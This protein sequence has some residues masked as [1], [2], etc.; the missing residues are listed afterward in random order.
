[1]C[2]GPST[3]GAG[4]K[5]RLH[6]PKA[7]TYHESRIKKFTPHCI[8]RLVMTAFFSTTYTPKTVSPRP[9]TDMMQAVES[10]VVAAQAEEGEAPA[11]ILISIEGNIG[12]GKSTVLNVLKQKHPDWVFIDEPV[13]TW[14]A[15]KNADGTNLL[16]HF[17]QDQ[18]R[19]AY[20]FQNCA[21]LSRFT[22]IENTILKTAHDDKDKAYVNYMKL[23]TIYVLHVFY[24]LILS[25]VC[26]P[27]LH[28]SPQHAPCM[29]S[30]QLDLIYSVC[31]C[32]CRYSSK[33]RIY[34][35]ERCLDTDKRVFAQMMYEDKKMNKIEMDLYCKWYHMLHQAHSG[36]A[37]ALSAIVYINTAPDVCAERIVK[38]S[39]GGEEGI[40]LEYVI[41]SGV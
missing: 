3:L 17:Y 15:L 4:A 7:V 32:V 9:H 1:M 40:P 39:R 26:Y 10:Q 20:T 6:T 11:P 18:V 5:T 37:T 33:R 28:S 30:K 2:C 25:M 27:C 34:I 31:S 16:E 13:D 14:T 12:A 24:F 36:D 8:Y 19:W 35:T 38:R 23:R 21:L 41:L 22:N 29:V